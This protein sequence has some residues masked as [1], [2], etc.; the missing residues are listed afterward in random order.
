MSALQ[1]KLPSNTQHIKDAYVGIVVMMTFCECSEAFRIHKYAIPLSVLDPFTPF[2][3]YP[4][5]CLPSH[6]ETKAA[7]ASLSKKASYVTTKYECKELY[8]FGEGSNGSIP[9]ASLLHS[10]NPEETLQQQ[11]II[12]NLLI[13]QQSRLF[14]E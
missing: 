5:G 4:S 6:L 13:T 2:P 14:I 3:N 11:K 7:T 9:K 10:S 12:Y 1:E 8:K